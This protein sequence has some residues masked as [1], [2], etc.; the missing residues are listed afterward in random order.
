MRVVAWD[1]GA[2]ASSIDGRW[3]SGFAGIIG[4]EDDVDTVAVWGTAL[5]DGSA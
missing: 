5:S 4:E 3:N 1:S 2:D